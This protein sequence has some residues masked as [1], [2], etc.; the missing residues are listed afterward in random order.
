MLETLVLDATKP[1]HRFFRPQTI[2]LAKARRDEFKR[3]AS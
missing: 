1:Y 3:G 2:H